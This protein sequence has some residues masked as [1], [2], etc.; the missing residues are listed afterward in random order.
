MKYGAEMSP[1]KNERRNKRKLQN[2]IIWEG[3]H[4]LF[5]NIIYEQEIYGKDGI[6][7]L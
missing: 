1:V 7:G 4:N 6:D 2:E 3:I 5:L